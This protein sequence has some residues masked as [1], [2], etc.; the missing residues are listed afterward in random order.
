VLFLHNQIDYGI[1]ASES[2]MPEYGI[3]MSVVRST[4]VALYICD[5]RSS[6]FTDHS[7]C[8]DEKPVLQDGHRRLTTVRWRLTVNEVVDIACY[9]CYLPLFFAGPLMTYENFHRQV[10]M[11]AV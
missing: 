9:I 2:M 8:D 3:S 10:S 6:M 1:T 7:K 5:I 11:L 4:S